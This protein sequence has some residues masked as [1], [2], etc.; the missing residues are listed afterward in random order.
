VK[1]FPPELQ[2]KQFVAELNGAHG[3]RWRV[4]TTGSDRHYLFSCVQ[5]P[6]FCIAVLKAELKDE[7]RSALAHGYGNA[8]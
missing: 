7:V 6:D 3:F 4:F 1:V 5:N 8:A 2:V